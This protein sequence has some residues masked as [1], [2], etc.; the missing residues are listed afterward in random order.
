MRSVPLGCQ[1]HSA[2]VPSSQASTTLRSSVSNV[3]C[4]LLPRP[5]PACIFC[6]YCTPFS[7]ASR[8]SPSRDCSHNW[9]STTGV[10]PPVAEARSQMNMSRDGHL[11]EYDISLCIQIVSSAGYSV[12]V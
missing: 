4:Q 10:A 8:T 5:T 3:T 12:E 6:V 2:P 7:N 9:V 11:E 1:V